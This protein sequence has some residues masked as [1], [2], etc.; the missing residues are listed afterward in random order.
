[1]WLRVHTKKSWAICCLNYPF[2]LLDGQNLLLCIDNSA[3]SQQIQKNYQY[4]YKDIF[5]VVAWDQSHLNLQ[6]GTNQPSQSP[7]HTFL[8]FFFSH[9]KITKFC[10]W[11]KTFGNKVFLPSYIANEK[12]YWNL[13]SILSIFLPYVLYTFCMTL[14]LSADKCRKNSTGLSQKIG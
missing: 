6:F 3:F 12:L 1:M 2:L 9:I 7:L 4:Y 11:N 10:S 13:P 8:H 14:C 5:L